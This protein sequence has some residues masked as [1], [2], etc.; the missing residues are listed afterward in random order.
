[1]NKAS[2]TQLRQS[3]TVKSNPPCVS[4]SILMILAQPGHKRVALLVPVGQLHETLP[5]LEREG[6]PF[7]HLY[8]C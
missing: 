1:L 3:A 6:V 5:S 8:D 4:M 7:D 2:F